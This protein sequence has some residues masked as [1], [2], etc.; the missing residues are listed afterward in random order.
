MILCGIS[1]LVL[2][3]PKKE[4]DC[5]GTLVPYNKLQPN[6]LPLSYEGMKLKED[7]DF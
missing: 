1:T 6:A 2:L 4:V 7:I 3:P 5:Q